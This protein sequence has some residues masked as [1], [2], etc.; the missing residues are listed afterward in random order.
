VT[1]FAQ[2]TLVSPCRPRMALPRKCA[3]AR[4]RGAG[5]ASDTLFAVTGAN[6]LRWSITHHRKLQRPSDS[7]NLSGITTGSLARTSK[8]RWSSISRDREHRRTSE[9]PTTRRLRSTVT[10]GNGSIG[11]TVA[12]GSDGT[13]APTTRVRQ[14]HAR[15][16]RRAEPVRAHVND[17]IVLALPNQV[18]QRA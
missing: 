14:L 10:I 18:A 1:L 5:L 11:V 3:T 12:I 9:R 17:P 4:D 13:S 16:V 2:G 7:G 8:S 6:A 15:R